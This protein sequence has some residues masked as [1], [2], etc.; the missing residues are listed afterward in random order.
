[1]IVTG[2]IILGIAVYSICVV[3]KIYKNR[4]NG[5]CCGGCSGCAGKNY[6]SK[7]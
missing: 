6:C 1:M 3:R 4:K 2:I 7:S 5:S